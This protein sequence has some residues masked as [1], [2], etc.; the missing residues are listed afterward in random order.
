MPDDTTTSLLLLRHGQSEWNAL[1]RWQGA[2]DSPLTDLG[3]AQARETADVLASIDDDFR[4]PWASDLVRASETAAIIGDALGIGS[5]THDERLRESHAGEW[6]GMTPDEI[7]AEYPGY[8]A[9]H[10]RP[11]GFEPFEQVVGRTLASLREIA[12][13]APGDGCRPLV[14]AHSGVIRSVVRH[15]GTTDSRIPNLGGVWFTIDTSASPSGPLDAIGIEIRDVFD[16]AGI[17]VSGVDAPGEDPG[18]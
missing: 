16:P 10:R 18:D 8:L 1:R 11:P 6:Q 9:A 12:H 13:P 15:L 14:V 17:V 5:V 2:A 4:G 3:R 7:E